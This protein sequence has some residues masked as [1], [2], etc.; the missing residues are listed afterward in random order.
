MLGQGKA[1]RYGIGVGREGFTWAGAEKVTRMAE[2]PDWTPP[3]EMIVRQPYL[4]RFMAGGETNPLGARAL[5][6]GENGVPHPRHQSAL[7]HRDLRVLGLYSPDQRRRCGP[8]HP[9]E[10]WHARG[11]AAGQAAGDRRGDVACSTRAAGR[12]VGTTGSSVGVAGS[13]AGAARRR[14]GDVCP[15]RSAAVGDGALTNTGFR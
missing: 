11:G 4:P 15:T 10:G 1:L 9:S 14:R 8:L 2:W 13:W 6:L 3:E 12:C 5:Y 7:D